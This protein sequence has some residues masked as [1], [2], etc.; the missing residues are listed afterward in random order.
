MTT[1]IG[2][3]NRDRGDDAAGLLVTDEL[4]AIASPRLTVVQVQGDPLR[5]LDGL[6]ADGQVVIVDAAGP[7]G[8][9]G[10]VHR[11]AASDLDAL[12]AYQGR[13]THGLGTSEVVRLGLATGKLP[14]QTIV[15][16]IEG[17]DFELGHGVSPFVRAAIPTAVAGILE[18]VR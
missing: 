4:L 6:Q 18:E 12:V 1:V 13:S 5:A 10:R 15:Y 16:G 17:E 11:L 7:S 3:G 14:R 2:I 9:P 8:R